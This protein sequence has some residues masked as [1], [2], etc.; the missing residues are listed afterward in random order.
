MKKLALLYAA[1]AAL[2]FMTLEPVSKLIA[3]NVS[4]YAITFWRFILGSLILFPFATVR[5]KKDNIKLSGKD[6][7]TLTGLGILF[8]CI[9][10]VSLQYA[11]KIAVSPALIA[12]IFSSNSVFSLLFAIPIIKETMTK[13]KILAVILCVI[14]LIICADFTKGENVRSIALALFSSLTFSLH[15]VLSQKYMSKMG[16]AVQNCIIFVA[17]SL[18]LLVALLITGQDLIP[19][20]TGK[21]VSLMLYLGFGVTGLGYF[22]FFKAIET[23][24]AIMGSMVFFFKPILTP[25]IT[26]IING[27][28]PDKKVFIALIFVAAGSVFATMEKFSRKK[29]AQ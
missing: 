15:S 20:F 25:F 7:L 27:I 6:F 18:I 21:S 13:N 11:V 3:D 8:I 9:S 24:G 10:M 17:G 19:E 4:P 28:I 5:I 22:L 16:A 14:G 2:L 1:V 23:G 12:I 26:L 29:K